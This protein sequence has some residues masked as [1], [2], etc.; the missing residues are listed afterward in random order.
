MRVTWDDRV[1]LDL[2]TAATCADIV[3][4]LE[5]IDERPTAVWCGAVRLDPDHRAGTPPLVHAASLRREQG[6]PDVSLA[7][8]HLAV[9]CGPDAGHMVSLTRSGISI[10]RDE[11]CDLVLADDALSRR[12]LRVGFDSAAWVSDDG[13]RNGTMLVR[14]DSTRKVARRLRPRPGERLAIGTS[15]IE[16]RPLPTASPGESSRRPPLSGNQLGAMGA[17]AMTGLLV[18]AMTGRWAFA[19]LALVFPAI[20]V[21]PALVG[22]L[23]RGSHARDAPLPPAD[24]CP[25]AAPS[26]VAPRPPA[27]AGPIAVV[28]DS[29]RAHATARALL[30]AR[31]TR[32]AEDSW[33]EP[34]M[35]WLPRASRDDSVVV[36]TAGNEAPSWAATVVDV[37]ARPEVRTRSSTRPAL[38]CGV[39]EATADTLARLISASTHVQALPADVAWADLVVATARTTGGERRLATPLGVSAGGNVVIDL[40]THGPHML[41]AG[42]TGA[43]KSALLETLVLGLA[44]SHSPDDLSIALIDFKGGAGLRH[45][46]RLPHVVGCLTDLDHRL[47]ERALTALGAEIDQ[48]KRDLAAAGHGSFKEWEAAGGAPPRLLVV[49]DEYQEVAQHHRAFLPHLARLAAQGRSLGL[50]LVLA[51]QRPAGAVT[52][53][54]RANVTTTIALRVASPTESQDLIGTADAAHLPIDRPGR[55]ILAHGADLRPFQVAR[56]AVSPTPPVRPAGQPIESSPEELSDAACERWQASTVP[57]P[58][59]REPLPSSV[60]LAQASGTRPRAMVL[61]LADW[62]VERRQEFVTW[63]PAD[64]P[65]AFVG[66]RGSGRTEA[67]LLLGH[68]ARSLGLTPVLL[69]VDPREAARTVSLTHHRE[70]VLLLIDN[71]GG[72]LAALN[73][74]D[75]GAPADLLLRRLARGLPAALS[76]AMH[77]QVRL[78]SAAGMTVVLS[79]ADAADD[80]LWN[81]PRNLG[82]LAAAAG[83]G[84]LG[85]G[86]R[87]CE[88]QLCRTDASADPTIARATQEWTLV[89]PLPSGAQVSHRCAGNPR[90]FAV[91][92]DDGRDIYLEGGEVTVIGPPTQERQMA[93][94]HI[95]RVSAQARVVGTRDELVT[96]PGSTRPIGTIVLLRPTSRG[97]RDA[98][99]T[100]HLG[101]A[102]PTPPT[103]RVVVINDQEAFVAQLPVAQGSAE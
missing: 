64:G 4:Y 85:R 54:I 88:I 103:G 84:R 87:W 9:V 17:G 58:L 25:H 52:P 89:R 68:Q 40:D 38:E 30:L 1:D 23:R 39:H 15:V 99:G 86:G 13:S 72:A 56:P 55:A 81:V 78:A 41:V 14:D 75:H 10:G 95:N 100:M 36:V 76:L 101:L 22:R 12:H 2:T 74:C 11:S 97:I 98:C 8:P 24:P 65:L 49:A 90:L 34:W 19:A 45:C 43:G 69:P 6:R 16:I 61:G 47:A 67:L 46:M 50:H 60:S 21:V 79:G 28:G 26:V 80:A 102:E 48:R 77:D 3:A 59:W 31:H 7:D 42:T 20:A 18:A 51:T 62:P 83:R 53:E 96:F 35:R 44:Y 92:G 70:D 57:P 32:P 71:A 5:G 29:F 93:V 73:D 33:Y 37:G 94:D 27:V 66:P 82:G 91:G 63:R